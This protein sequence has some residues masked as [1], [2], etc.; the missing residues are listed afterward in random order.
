MVV[1]CTIKGEYGNIK[2]ENASKLVRIRSVPPRLQKALN[3]I[4]SRF[5]KGLQVRRTCGLLLI[6]FNAS[7]RR[8]F[9]M[10]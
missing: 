6:V 3:L 7:A 4:A 9:L 8:D 5:G 1:Y 2:Q 10:G